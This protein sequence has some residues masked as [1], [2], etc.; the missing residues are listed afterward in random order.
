MTLAC[1]GKETEMNDD[2]KRIDIEDIPKVAEEL[3]TRKLRMCRVVR[4]PSTAEA[5]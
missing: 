4:I 1:A 3:T 5:Y 2:E